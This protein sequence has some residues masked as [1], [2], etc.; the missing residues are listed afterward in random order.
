MTVGA[1]PVL[2]TS[3]HAALV[4]LCRRLA[5]QMD[6]GG[7]EVSSHVSA[8]YLSALKDMQR[9]VA[10]V[11]GTP[12]AAEPDTLAAARDEV[13]GMRSRRVGRSA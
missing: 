6:A 4:A 7:L 3:R 11:A 8:A 2:G 13:S 12:G 5:D 1:V 9:A 10:A